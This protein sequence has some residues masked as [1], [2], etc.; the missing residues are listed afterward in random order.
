MSVEAD[1]IWAILR[2]VAS[3]QKALQREVKEVNKNI[4]RLT[5]RLGEFVEEAVRPSAVRLFRDRGID[6]HEV[7][8]NVS[9]KRD[10]EALEIDLLVV[11]NEDVVVIECKSNL[12]IDDVNEQLERL[13]KVK[14]LLPRY[15][16]CRILGAVAG[17]VIPDNVATYAIRKGL[18]VIGQSGEHLELRNDISFAAKVW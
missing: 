13:E 10:G 18:Y 12:S 6:I 9:A 11:N 7:Q 1:E 14:R 5:N 4:G 17:M 8:Q 15:K 3:E 16:D 2:E